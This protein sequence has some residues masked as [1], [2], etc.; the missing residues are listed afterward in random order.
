MAGAAP[1]LAAGQAGS[2]PAQV[3]EMQMIVADQARPPDAQSPIARWR[4]DHANGRMPVDE[5]VAMYGG[6][7][8]Q[9]LHPIDC[10]PQSVIVAQIIELDG[11]FALDGGDPHGL[12]LESALTAFAAPAREALTDDWAGQRPVTALYYRD[13]FGFVNQVCRPGLG[14]FC[15][16]RST[17]VGP[18]ARERGTKPQPLCA[19]ARRSSS[20]PIGRG[21][22]PQQLEVHP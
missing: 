11:I 8:C 3:G 18:R 2:L 5:V 4:L 7:Q 10:H 9:S 21:R 22:S 14:L 6:E 16:S 1:G 19:T 17:A 12:A 20:D 15:S 13:K